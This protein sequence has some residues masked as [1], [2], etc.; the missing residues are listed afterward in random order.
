MGSWRNS[1]LLAVLDKGI[2][3][4][5]IREV[6]DTFCD[7]SGQ[8][9][10]LMKSKVYFSPNVK[11]DVRTDLCHVLGFN[12]TPNLGKYLGF[13]IHNLDLHPMIFIFCWIEFRGS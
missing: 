9:V 11:V 12:S 8:K 3:F 7:F 6:L 10:N 4:C 13:L 5:N 2:H 1:N